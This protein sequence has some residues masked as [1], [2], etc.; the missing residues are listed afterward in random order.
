MLKLKYRR[1]HKEAEAVGSACG[2]QKVLLREVNAELIVKDKGQEAG[3]QTRK[4]AS[5]RLE[6]A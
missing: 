3:I 4:T 2:S 5:A 6:R 1:S